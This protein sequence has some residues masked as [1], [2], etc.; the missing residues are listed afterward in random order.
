MA[1]LI[2]SL[3]SQEFNQRKKRRKLTHQAED[4]AQNDNTNNRII[5]KPRWKTQAEQQIYSSKL[6]E[7]LRRS[8]QTSSTAAVKGREI[9]ETA[10]RLL[11]VTAKGKTRWSRAILAGRLRMRKVKKARKVKV[12]GENRLRKKEMAKE[13]SRLP[14]VEDR[15]RVLSRLVPGCQKT[16]F[17][18][19]LEEAGDYIAALEMQVKAMTALTE[20]LAAGGVAPVRPTS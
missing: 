7:A 19:L 20:I 5:V 2:S 4:H 15:V 6:L 14:V 1:S 10:D 17:T 13:S 9:R 3:E 18:N 8:R 12:T 11:A 16:S